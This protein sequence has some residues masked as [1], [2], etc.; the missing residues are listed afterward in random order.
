MDATANDSLWSFSV[1]AK[2]HHELVA[3]TSCATTTDLKM[4]WTEAAVMSWVLSIRREWTLCF[5]A[6]FPQ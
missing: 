4:M 2:P 5:L 1:V 3:Y 6:I